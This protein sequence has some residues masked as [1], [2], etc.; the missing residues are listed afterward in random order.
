MPYPSNPEARSPAVAPSFDVVTVRGYT[1]RSGEERAAYT[2][3]GAAWNR[4]KGGFR[5]RLDALPLN[6]TIF[7][8][9]RRSDEERA[10]ARS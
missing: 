10:A 1:D 4:E 3:I 6:E 7:L 8:F 9:E 2:R 5:L